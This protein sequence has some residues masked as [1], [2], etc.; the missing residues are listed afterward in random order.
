MTNWRVLASISLGFKPFTCSL[1]LVDYHNICGAYKQAVTCSSIYL[2][3]TVSEITAA[4]SEVS[5]S[6]M[7]KTLSSSRLM[8]LSGYCVG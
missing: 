1:S 5:V 8:A 2:I 6:V 4:G 7:S 3:Y